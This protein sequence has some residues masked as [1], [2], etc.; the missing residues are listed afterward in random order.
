MFGAS[1]GTIT[2]VLAL[3]ALGAVFTS[4]GAGALSKR[5]GLVLA[6][7]SFHIPAQILTIL[8][9]FA[10]GANSAFAL[11]ISRTCLSSLDNSV[12]GAFLAGITP[13]ASRTR[14]LGIVEVARSLSAGP[15]PF[16]TGRLVQI[17]KLH[18]AFVISGS[19]KILSDLC[20]LAG[21]SAV[22]FEH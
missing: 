1:L 21:F 4:L 19:V 3:A 5:A 9:A 8:T 6:M 2:K 13:A 12:R 10:P 17:D 7:T 22:K 18:L 14:F 16:V 20:L 15:A 11:Y